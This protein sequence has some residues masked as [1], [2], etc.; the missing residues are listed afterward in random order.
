MFIL[1]NMPNGITIWW[2]G[3]N[4]AYVDVPGSFQGTVQGLCGTFTG[5]MYDD[6]STPDGDIEND[7]NE[8]ANQ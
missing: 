6:F 3:V 1:A 5:N 2:D 7:P 8:F 4:R